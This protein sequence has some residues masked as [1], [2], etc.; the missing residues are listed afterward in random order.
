MFQLRTR[1]AATCYSYATHNSMP[2]ISLPF[3]EP[4]VSANGRKAAITEKES[5]MLGKKDRCQNMV[6]DRHIYLL[7]TVV[8]AF[9]AL[10]PLLQGQEPTTL[11]QA[12]GTTHIGTST[13]F[14][15]TNGIINGPHVESNRKLILEHF[16]CIQPAVYPAWGGYWPTEQPAAVEHY[17]FWTEPLSSQAE[18]AEQNDLYVIH[19]G[20]LSPNYYFPKW[21]S[22]TNYSSE[23]LEQILKKYVQAVVSVPHVDTWNM[24]NELF[25]GDGSYFRDGNDEWD[26]K[27]MGIGME[28]DASGLTGHAQVNKQHPRF[29][30]IALEHAARF[31]RGKLELREGT[32]FQNPRK[33]DALYQLVLHIKNSG[34]PLHAIGIQGHLD[35]DGTYDFDAFQSQVK[36]FQDAGV[37]FYVTELDVGLPKNENPETA[38][39]EKIK[40]LQ[41]QVYYEFIKAARQAGVTLISVWG[42]T[43]APEGGWRGGERALLFSKDYSKKPTYESVLKALIETGKS[44]EATSQRSAEYSPIQKTAVN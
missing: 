32:T 16:N 23:E 42:M 31:T 21:W 13:G 2:R 30:R 4:K 40:P 26:N 39:W 6:D 27:W 5:T 35:Y 18:W 14:N 17:S 19:H 28:P 43:D 24:F 10:T 25:L 3:P 36:S 29:I 37:E 41:E 9:G 12:A 22:K 8:L 20:I 7:F 33:L 15:G 34:T 38:D 1:F 11:K 44:G